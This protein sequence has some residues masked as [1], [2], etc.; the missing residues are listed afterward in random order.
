MKHGIGR[1]TLTEREL[2][3]IQRALES[4]VRPLDALEVRNIIRRARD[5]AAL[6]GKRDEK[7]KETT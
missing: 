5:V 3:L 7:R 1:A 2:F 4:D 6:R